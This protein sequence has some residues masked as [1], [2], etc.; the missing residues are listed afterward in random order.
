M[1]Y[2]ENKFKHTRKDTIILLLRNNNSADLFFM[3]VLR[4][5][6]LIG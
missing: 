3:F 4:C 1:S 5:L 2:C 6:D